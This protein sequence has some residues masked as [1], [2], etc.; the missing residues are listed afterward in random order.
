MSEVVREVPEPSGEEVITLDIF[1]GYEALWTLKFTDS[2]SY[3]YKKSLTTL[4]EK[5]IGELIE[6]GNKL[7][8]ANTRTWEGYPE[9]AY[10]NRCEIDRLSQLHMSEEAKEAHRENCRIARNSWSPEVQKEVSKY[11]SELQK[12]IWASLSPEDRKLKCKGLSDGHRGKPSFEIEADRQ[13]NSK[14]QKERIAEM[15]EEQFKTWTSNIGRSNSGGKLGPSGQELKLG[16]YLETRFPDKWAFNGQLQ[17][18]IKIEDKI[19]DFVSTSTKE[20]IELFGT[21]WHN[22][23]EELI[24]VT[25]F[26][27]SGW[28]CTIVWDYQLNDI[29]ELDNFFGL[30]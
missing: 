17:K 6:I 16:M 30:I 29:D 27:K 4:S 8:K 11:M 24:R 26:K 15:S 25:L 2:N 12:G 10:K 9:A 21:H 22:E 3:A 1:K 7:A 5:S 28:S 13:Y 19:P 23:E 20:I 14:L 18:G